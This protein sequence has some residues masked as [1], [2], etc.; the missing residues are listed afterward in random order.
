M[1]GI[2]D[3]F[4]SR[5]FEV[6]RGET[7]SAVGRAFTDLMSALGPDEV[8]DSARETRLPRRAGQHLADLGRL[9]SALDGA[10]PDELVA[11]RELL[12]ASAADAIRR[13]R[14][15]RQ[16]DLPRLNRWQAA[17][18]HKIN[19]DAGEPPDPTLAACLAEMCPGRFRGLAG[20]GLARL[21]ADL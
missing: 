7:V 19:G 21:Q 9:H 10:L 15:Y 13:L 4:W 14:V 5:S 20:S 3:A 17:L 2:P 11:I 12:A 8:L 6:A 1:A 16:S 18:M